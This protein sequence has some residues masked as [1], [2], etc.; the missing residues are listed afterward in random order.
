MSQRS[1]WRVLAT[2]AVVASLAG[3]CSTSSDDSSSAT[4]SATSDGKPTASARGVTV[5]SIK[6]GFSYPDL[7]ALAK[8]GLLKIDNG[9]YDEI[10][11][12]IVDD[13][14]AR[15]GVN[16]RKLDVTVAKFSVLG[17]AEQLA[18]CTKFTEDE[19]VFAVLGGFLTDVNLCVTQQHSTPLVSGYG[20]GFNQAALAKARAPWVTWN[21]S[22]ERAV[23]ALVKLLDKQGRLN[24]KTIG[25]EGQTPQSKS[26]V[27]QTVKALKDAGY[28]VADTAIIDVDASD[29]QAFTAQD[30]LLAQRFKDKGVD[31][32]FLVGGAPTGSNYD[33]VDWHPSIF[34]PQTALITPTAFTSPF[35]KFP[36]VAG[37][38]GSADPDA[39]YDT[40]AM[41][42]CRAAYKKATG[43]DVKTPTQETAD[44]KSSGFSAMQQTCTAFQIFVEGAKAAGSNLTAASW[45]KGL[46]SL[47]KIVLPAS[48]VASFAPNKPDAQ[49]SFQLMQHDPAWTPT[50]TTPEFKPL[51]EPITLSN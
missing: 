6:L 40:P 35:Q 42:Q 32:F 23:K 27:D 29:Q 7:E 18:A 24:G 38:A 31:A 28:D 34:V 26:L 36:L 48:P 46:E 4:T 41:K 37:V 39:G 51:G 44:G 21:A 25:V 17:N 33:A 8:T 9:P 30:K 1:P 45:E 3:A 13:I 50:A 43:K 2:L 47:G 22:D 11:K 10:V 12:A 16:G 14:N 15:G 5:D 20:T 49:D 19:K